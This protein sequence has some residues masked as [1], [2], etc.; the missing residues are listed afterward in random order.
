MSVVIIGGNECMVRQYKDL[1]ME[2]SCD[3]KVFPK[4]ASRIRNL[5]EPDIM[6]LFTGTVSHKMVV[7]AMNEVKGKETII[8]RSHS[9][10][11]AA[12]KKILESHT[13]SG[14]SRGRSQ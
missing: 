12:L 8:E 11:M 9:S 14:Q 13:G 3:V 1:G 2:Y 6:V 10:S 4:K 5:K 7:S